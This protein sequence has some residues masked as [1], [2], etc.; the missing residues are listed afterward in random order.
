MALNQ[1]SLNFAKDSVVTIACNIEDI[2]GTKNIELELNYKGDSNTS[3][4]SLNS[5]EKIQIV[6]T[7]RLYKYNYD[8]SKLDFIGEFEQN[9]NNFNKYS[10]KLNSNSRSNYIVLYSIRA[11]KDSCQNEVRLSGLSKG[12]G[13]LKIYAK[14]ELPDLY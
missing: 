2:V 8:D 11:N 3:N 14:E 9:V 5:E 1:A 12:N 10:V 7:P 4:E 6:E 13:T